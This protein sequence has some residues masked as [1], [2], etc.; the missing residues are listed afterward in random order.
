MSSNCSEKTSPVRLSCKSTHMVIFILKVLT[1]FPKMDKFK[2]ALS[3]SD[4]IDRRITG[5]VSQKS[6]ANQIIPGNFSF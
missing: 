1:Y 2:H 6:P 5:N 3:S 4:G